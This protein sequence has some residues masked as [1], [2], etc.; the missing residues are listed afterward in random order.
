MVLAVTILF[1]NL[2]RILATQ[3]SGTGVSDY[4]GLSF[5]LR[6]DIPSRDCMKY[7]TTFSHVTEFAAPGYYQVRLEDDQIETE[8]TTTMKAGMHQYPFTNGVANNIILDLQPRDEV[9]ESYLTIEDSF[10][11]SGFR[12]IKACALNLY[13]ILSTILI[14][15]HNW[16]I[17]LKSKFPPYNAGGTE[18]LIEGIYATTD[19]ANWK[20][21]GYQ[22]RISNLA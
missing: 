22:K 10:K 3:L 21:A 8:F 7:Y 18:R 2:F 17:K 11:I 14:D 20:L 12:R 13:Y 19:W 5:S 4:G 16:S 6:N 9:L 1:T 15:S